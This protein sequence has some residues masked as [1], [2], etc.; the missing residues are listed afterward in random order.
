MP[1]QKETDFEAVVEMSRSWDARQAG[2]EVGE[3]IMKRMKRPSKFVLFFATIHYE[4]HG[5]F[6]ELLN[7][8]YDFL[9]KETPL[10]GGTVAGFI[11]NS[12]CYARGVAALAVYYPNMKIAVG[13]GD[14]TKRNPKKAA[15]KCAIMISKGLEN[16]GYPNK[17]LTHIVS[18]AKMLSFPIVGRKTVLNIPNGP[19]ISLLVKLSTLVVQHGVARANDVLEELAERLPNFYFMGGE[20]ADDNKVRENVQFFNDKV[21]ENAVVAIGAATDLGLKLATRYEATMNPEKMAKVTKTGGWKHVLTKINGKPARRELLRLLNWP[22]GYIDERVY[23]RVFFYPIGYENEN[24][25]HPHVM[26]AFIGDS[27]VF[28]YPMAAPNI[29]VLNYSGR[30]IDAAAEQVSAE[31][32]ETKP[33]LGFGNACIACL[34]ALRSGAYSMIHKRLLKVFDEK[35]F[36]M[37]FLA[38]EDFKFPN[39]PYIHANYS[40]NM[41]AIAGK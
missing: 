8:V 14:N 36:L 21:Y 10:V 35:P 26:G 24:G 25:L 3:A 1:Q 18:G 12:G 13:I 16:S 31:L 9:P 41:L 15:A 20:A 27:I 17:F 38:G 29:C 37:L 23:R 40:L 30:T 11:N 39:K 4:K 28:E 33:L 34:E 2:R 6:Q 22:E 5:G 19:H 7:G 32:E